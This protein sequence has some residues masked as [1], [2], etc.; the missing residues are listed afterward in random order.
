MTNGQLPFALCRCLLRE[1]A[2][3]ELARREVELY[4]ALLEREVG[5]EE[6][7]RLIAAEA[8]DERRLLA[9]NLSVRFTIFVFDF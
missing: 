2:G 6:P 9:G 3:L 5:V 7:A 4:L 1:P 8:L